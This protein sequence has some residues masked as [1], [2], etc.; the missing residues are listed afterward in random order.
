MQVIIRYLKSFV[1]PS[2]I[3]NTEEY[4]LLVLIS[5]TTI[6]LSDRYDIVYN[7]CI[8]WICVRKRGSVNEVHMPT[9]QS[10]DTHP[11]LSEEAASTGYSTLTGSLF[12]TLD[13]AV[14]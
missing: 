8:A 9:S 14:F 13:T 5:A 7:L 6:I 1:L 4:L 2:Y 11:T 12:V 3:N 10:Q